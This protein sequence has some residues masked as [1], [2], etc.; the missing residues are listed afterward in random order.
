MSVA[1]SNNTDDSNTVSDTDNESGNTVIKDLAL[2]GLH[3][4]RKNYNIVS[5]NYHDNES[6]N[7]LIKDLITPRFTRRNRFK[8]NSNTSG[9]NES[10]N[11]LIKDLVKHHCR[12]T[13]NSS[14]DS[15]IETR[16]TNY[17]KPTTT[18]RLTQSSSQKTLAESTFKTNSSIYK[19]KYSKFKI[20]R[21]LNELSKQYSNAEDVLE[22]FIEIIANDD[23][24]DS[25]TG[26]ESDALNLDMNE[27]EASVIGL[28]RQFKP[29]RLAED[30][31]IIASKKAAQ[32]T[33][34]DINKAC[35]LP[36]LAVP[37]IPVENEINNDDQQTNASTSL[38]TDKAS[39]I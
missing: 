39:F 32:P 16:N 38:L 31:V 11:T 30:T 29:I 24:D 15:T 1:T 33:D 4:K 2:K 17:L 10:G 13:S 12:R 6:G 21:I 3:V 19:K 25:S 18:K 20:E 28:L 26:F 27:L 36:E 22:T 37:P 8:Y 14:D 5:N 9:E 7:T 34:I 23:N 35:D